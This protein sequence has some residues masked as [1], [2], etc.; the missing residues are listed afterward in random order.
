MDDPTRG[1]D[2]ETR[3]DIYRK[4]RE[5][6]ASGVAVLVN[7]T[8]TLE[9]MGLCDGVLVMFEGRVATSSPAK[10]SRKRRSSGPRS[11]SKEKP[12]P[13]RRAGEPGAL[14][15]NVRESLSTR[16]R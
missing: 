10:P 4:I 6:A 3:R 11:E 2:I 12:M 8:D 5:I 15:K 16:G 13:P 1:V 7:S 14:W 9:L